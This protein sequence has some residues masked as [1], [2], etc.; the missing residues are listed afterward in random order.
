MSAF[1]PTGAAIV[2]G[3]KIIAD[4]ETWIRGHSC[5]GARCGNCHEPLSST[6]PAKGIV[7][8]PNGAGY[9]IYVL[10]RHCGR[11][12]KRKGSAGIPNAVRDA[13]LA[14]LLY[15]MPAKGRA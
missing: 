13:K 1:A 14:T 11:R 2:T 10:C 4:V 12:F 7:G 3:N 8:I 5:S 6:R 15:F 9:S